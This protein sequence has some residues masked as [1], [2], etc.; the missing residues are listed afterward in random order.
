MSFFQPNNIYKSQTNSITEDNLKIEYF[1]CLGKE[2]Y[3]E[4]SVP[5]KKKDGPEVYAKK[6][7]KQ[8]GSIK[9]SIKTESNGKLFNPI[10]MYGIEKNNTFLDR[11]CKSNDRFKTVNAKAFEWYIKFLSTKTIGWLYNAE[12][13]M[14]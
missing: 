6:I 12:R 1:T 2:D 10:S 3:L 5:Y 9:Y 13:E 8:D 4:N 7:E 14:E 11:V